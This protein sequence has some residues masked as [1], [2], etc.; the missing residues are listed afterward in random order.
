LFEA[1]RRILQSRLDACKT[2]AERNRLGQFATPPALAQEI[3][4]HGVSLLPPGESIRFLDPAVGTGAFFSA[5]RAVVSPTRIAAA[6]GF[7]IDAHYGE[8]SAALWRECGL[9]YRIEDFTTAR[10]RSRFN[11]LICNPPYVRHHHLSG[12]EKRRLRRLTEAASGMKLS[13]LSGLYCHFVGLSRGWLDAGGVAGWLLP[14]E[15]MDVNY[16]QALKRYLLESTTLLQIHRF[17]PVEAQFAD[18]QVTSAL[19]WFRSSPPPR[20]HSVRFTFGGT[21]VAPSASR[22]VETS[23]LLREPKWT[24]FPISGVRRRRATAVVADFFSIKRGLATGNNGYFI[25][26]RDEILARRLPLEVFRPILPSPRYLHAD[27]VD[28]DAAGYPLLERQLFLLHVSLEEDEIAARYPA[29]FEYLQ[30]GRR[31]GL[32]RTYLCRHRE[33]WYSQEKRPA[34]PIVCTYLG[35]GSPARPRPFRFILNRSTATA[36]NV[37]LLMYPTARLTAALDREPVLIESVRQVL[38]QLTLEDLSGAGRIY[39]GGL[40]KLEPR[41]LAN[42][43]VPRLARLLAALESP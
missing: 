37:Y 6:A 4:R 5:L 42:V 13:G 32:H 24:R 8:P 28:G 20:G 25:L 30:E 19:V 31:R 35:R 34:A 21:F 15:F 40:H 43:R 18:A 39:G 16:G 14:S 27:I 1:S 33:P 3:L 2:P 12:E 26:G 41:E 7:E 11:L 22:A 23:N 9:D 29:L 36:S 38:D 10:S 17:D